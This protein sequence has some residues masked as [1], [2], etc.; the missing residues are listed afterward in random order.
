MQDETK[1]IIYAV[2]QF[3]TGFVADIV[4]GKVSSKLRTPRSLSMHSRTICTPWDSCEGRCD[5]ST[6]LPP[7]T[8]FCDSL[9]SSYG[10]CCVDYEEM[11]DISLEITEKNSE[12][13][14]QNDHF[15]QQIYVSN[16]CPSDFNI[17]LFNTK[18]KTEIM[19]ISSSDGRVYMN[20]YCAQCNDIH[21]NLS[22][23]SISK[24]G[25]TFKPPKLFP[26]PRICFNAISTCSRSG[27]KF[28]N[29]DL[30]LLCR[31]F[32]GPV[33]GGK[34]KLFYKN[35]FC[36]FCNGEELKN[37]SCP[38]WSFNSLKS[39]KHLENNLRNFFSE[40]TLRKNARGKKSGDIPA[41]FSI[42]LNFGLDGKERMMFSSDDEEDIIKNQ[43][44]CGNSKIWDPFSNICRSLYCSTEYVLVDFTCVP[45]SEVINNPNNNE[46][47]EIIDVES[48]CINLKLNFDID[49]SDLIEHNILDENNLSDHVQEA[50]S[51]FFQISPNRIQDM[52]ITLLSNE[53]MYLYNNSISL[54]ETLQNA[55][56][57]FEAEFKLCELVNCT[58]KEPSVDNIVSMMASSVSL[59]TFYLDIA[60]V[61]SK[62]SQIHQTIDSMSNWCD[63]VKGRRQKE[64][65]NQ[66][67]TLILNEGNDH[68]NLIKHAYINK[69]GKTYFKGQFLANILFQGYRHNHNLINVSGFVVVCEN[70]QI[71]LDPSCTRLKLEKEEYQILSNGTLTYNGKSE[72]SSSLNLSVYE[73]IDN[74]SVLVCY[75]GIPY[76][77]KNWIAKTYLIEFDTTQAYLS[78]ILT[79]V[80][81]TA[82]VAV[83]ITY[84]LIS[85]LRNLPG[86]NTIFLT[87]TLLL[88]QITFLLGQ[89]RTVT[90]VLCQIVGVLTHFEILSSLFWMNIM[91]YDQYKTFGNKNMLNFDRS[92]K[93]LFW[94]IL[95]AY[96]MPAIIVFLSYLMDFFD[97]EYGAFYGLS[98]VCWITN[99][100]AALL[101]F[102]TP[103][104]IIIAVNIILFSFTVRA[105]AKIHK[106]IRL[107]SDQKQKQNDAFLYLRMAT[108]MG[109][110]WILAFLA[111]WYPKTRVAGQIL[112]YLFIIFNTLQGLFIFFGFI[113]N[114]RVLQYYKG[115]IKKLKLPKLNVCTVCGK[116]RCI[117]ESKQIFRSSSSET[118]FSS[119]SE[120]VPTLISYKSF[121]G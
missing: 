1:K 21:K 47:P 72:L 36:A 3:S 78:L 117:C 46:K 84:I 34:S 13:C 93:T 68:T 106:M 85:K 89:R 94:Y 118:T 116:F 70:D 4:P 67:F 54:N 60:N 39:L 19:P 38:M 96:G 58:K 50:L 24:D 30:D 20:P 91:A 45:K 63:P 23:W 18:C 41:A 73:R 104:A 11:C 76:G 111:A 43:R 77:Y 25:S 80:S 88:M 29:R 42:L 35:L 62:V 110:T 33:S 51:M 16:S 44:R 108:V 113:C 66:D 69:T 55:K 87:I 102:A 40:T 99:S 7:Y 37:L 103:L 17:S 12:V 75:N 82:L 27:M 114:K 105:I 22:L 10:D 121:K 15:P 83:L 98:D 112:A 81:I 100:K 31:K 109:F 48:E 120:S 101:F 90:G 9:C 97:E 86:W 64:Y 49:F 6:L 57:T 59:D 61:K 8:C 79:C 52:N 107:K 56:M 53:T 71:K 95:Y 65:W 2:D 5:E 115:R 26:E 92:T 14:L 74:D 28:H 119:V 32:S